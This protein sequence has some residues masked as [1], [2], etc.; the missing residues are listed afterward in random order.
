MKWSKQARVIYLPHD[1]L[2]E[3]MKGWWDGSSDLVCNISAIRLMSLRCS[4]PPLCVWKVRKKKGNGSAAH[5]LTAQREIIRAGMSINHT[6]THTYTHTP[7]IHEILTSSLATLLHPILINVKS[8]QHVWVAPA[9]LACIRMAGTAC[10][11]SCIQKESSF[12][13]CG[14]PQFTVILELEPNAEK[15]TLILLHTRKT[16]G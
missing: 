9:L 12:F 5:Q 14:G 7:C 6:W 15:N 2:G 13:C 8:E 4:S 11:K 1:R 10:C 3:K 16:K